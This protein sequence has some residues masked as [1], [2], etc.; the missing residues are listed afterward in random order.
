[1]SVEIAPFEERRGIRAS[2]QRT[3]KGFSGGGGK[4]VD[5]LDLL[6]V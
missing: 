2:L 4:G 3:W 1:M 5:G 6:T